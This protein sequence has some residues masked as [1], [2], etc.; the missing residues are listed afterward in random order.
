MNLDPSLGM[1]LLQGLFAGKVF[2][3]GKFGPHRP[4]TMSCVASMGAGFAFQHLS[5]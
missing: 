4:G 2:Q 1:G 5:F 3:T